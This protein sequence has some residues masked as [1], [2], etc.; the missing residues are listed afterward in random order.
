MPT[1]AIVL[2]D[3]LFE[4]VNAKTSHGLVRGTDRF[5]ILGVIDGSCAGRDA[6]EVLDGKPRGIPVFASI[7]AA[8]ANCAEPPRALIVGVATH[9]GALPDSLR[10]GLLEAADAGLDLVNG[11]HQFLED[12]AEIAQ[13][14]AAS[15]GQITDIRKPPLAGSLGF[16]SGAAL[17]MTTPKVAILGTDCAIGKRTTCYL[18]LDALREAG[19]GAEMIYTGQTGWL[20]G[21]KH[22]FIL[23]ATPN[24]FVSGELER[25]LIACEAELSP[26]V[27]LLEGQSALRNPAGPCGSEFILS[28]GAR[29]AIL[30][31]APARRCFDDLEGMGCVI[32]SIE[33]EIELV[34]LLG[35]RV[36]GIALNEEGLDESAAQQALEDMQDKVQLPVVRPLHGDL[37][38]LVSAMLDF[39]RG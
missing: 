2:A 28:G 1:P 10:G 19:L 21:I 7:G 17:R 8:L 11:L 33:S 31:H 18:L 9:G 3:Q 6:G 12:D 37:G 30:Q 24:D 25:A 29:G 13:R 34:G 5:R 16:W 15:G 23:D 20:Q 35:A 39:I 22:G 14:V 27:I 32:P 4:T 36:L 38:P 26:E